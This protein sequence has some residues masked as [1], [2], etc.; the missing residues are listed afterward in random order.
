MPCILTCHPNFS[1]SDAHYRYSHFLFFPHLSSN[2]FHFYPI[3]SNLSPIF[4]ILL[5][6]I[7][8]HF[9]LFFLFLLFSSPSLFHP[10]QCQFLPRLAPSP[11]S[12]A[13]PFASKWLETKRAAY[14]YIR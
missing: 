9:V 14:E 8:P 4:L 10:L 11:T 2:F 6:H 13:F 5:P 7:F 12:P 3:L 1:I